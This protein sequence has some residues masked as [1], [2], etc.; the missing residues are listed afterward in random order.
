MKN[1]KFIILLGLLLIAIYFVVDRVIPYSNFS[2]DQYGNYYWANKW[3]LAGHLFGGMIAL[4]IGPFQF[5]KS[6]RNKYLKTHRNLG[7]AY[8]IAI[9]ISS[10]CAIYMS[11]TVAPQVNSAWSIALFFLAFAWLASVLMA[12]R[13]IRKRRIIQHQEWMIRSYVIT[14]GF[15]LFRFIDEHAIS[16]LFMKDFAERGPTCIWLAWAVP[17]FFAEIALQ[18]NKKQ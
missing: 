3:W 18:W 12:Y 14:F 5:N 2:I 17:L 15:V 4:L 10:L 8:I 11:F 16:Q 6:F 13:A 9:I 1:F 7:K